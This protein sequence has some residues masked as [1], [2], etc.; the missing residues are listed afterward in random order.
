MPPTESNQI[1]KEQLE[2]VKT[3][4]EIQNLLDKIREQL[5]QLVVSAYR[6]RRIVKFSCE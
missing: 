4:R 3:E 2:L 1:M 6:I 5:N